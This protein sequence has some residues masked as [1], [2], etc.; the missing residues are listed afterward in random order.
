MFSLMLGGVQKLQGGKGSRNST[1]PSP[2]Q[3][4][5]SETQQEATEGPVK[6]EEMAIAAEEDEFDWANQGKR[7]GSRV[8]SVT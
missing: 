4:N 6:T 1:L 7:K 2:V 5:V 8:A 3:E